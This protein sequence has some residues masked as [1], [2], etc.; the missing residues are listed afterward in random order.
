M[1]N[2]KKVSTPLYDV[3]R[4]RYQLFLDG[5]MLRMVLSEGARHANYKGDVKQ[6]GERGREI[7]QKPEVQAAF[8]ELA[9]VKRAE[10]EDSK[11]AI[12]ERLKLQASVS[13]YDLCKW[14]D[15]KKQWLIRPPHEVDHVWL[16]V[17]G[18]ISLSRENRPVFNQGAQDTARKQLAAYMLWD[19]ALRDDAPAVSFDF[20]LKREEYS[21]TKPAEELT[22]TAAQQAAQH[23][24][25]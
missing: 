16:P 25:H 21:K 17:L 12:I 20:S 8:D 24:E 23:L 18:L 4:P 2:K 5:Y 3:L 10:L 15:D 7:I 6:L 19:K 22:L 9:A 1:S 14:C 13:L 11:T